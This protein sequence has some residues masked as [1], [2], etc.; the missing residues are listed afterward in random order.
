MAAGIDFNAGTGPRRMEATARRAIGCLICADLK[1][2]EE[3]GQTF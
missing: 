2:T 3:K 1:A